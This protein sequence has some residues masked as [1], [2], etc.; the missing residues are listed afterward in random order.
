MDVQLVLIVNV[1][2]WRSSFL[3][4]ALLT[5][6]ADLSV[7]KMFFLL[8]KNKSMRMLPAQLK[9][10]QPS[11]LHWTKLK[12]KALER[13]QRTQ[14]ARSAG[15][16]ERPGNV[17]RAQVPGALFDYSYHQH[18][19]GIH[20]KGGRFHLKGETQWLLFNTDS[21]I[22]L[23]SCSTFFFFFF[24]FLHVYIVRFR[25]ALLMRFFSLVRTDECWK[26]KMAWSEKSVQDPGTGRSSTLNLI[27]KI[28]F[29][30]P[31]CSQWGSFIWT[32]TG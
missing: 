14:A 3:T 15:W 32:N 22:T 9:E 7:A 26:I 16:S 11:G 27:P 30:R 24:F 2:S 20:M 25:L 19:S 10:F 17:A 18:W 28:H 12:G 5:E 23:F 6:R 4:G 21:R 13:G 8:L 29:C 1:V 31:S